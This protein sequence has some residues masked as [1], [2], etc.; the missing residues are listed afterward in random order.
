MEKSEDIV[1]GGRYILCRSSLAVGGGREKRLGVA[2]N[3]SGSSSTKQQLVATLLESRQA[4]LPDP[5][6]LDRTTTC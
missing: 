5:A 4:V 6:S 2:Q 3:A 1:R